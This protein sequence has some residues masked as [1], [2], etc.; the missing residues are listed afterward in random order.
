MRA[1]GVNRC[2]D[3]LGRV[4]IPKELRKVN[5]WDEGDA[6]E[7]FTDADTVVIRKYERGCT[8]CGSMND[9]KGL[10]GKDVCGY[11]REDI[12]K[13][14]KGGAKIAKGTM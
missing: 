1:T 6:V 8:F 3:D 12:R 5:K 11:C 10:F 4:V 13:L 14:Y 9:L 2:I 7:F